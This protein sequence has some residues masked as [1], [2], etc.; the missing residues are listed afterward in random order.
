[1]QKKRRKRKLAR[2]T[3]GM[4]VVMCPVLPGPRCISLVARLQGHV[5]W[6]CSRW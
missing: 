2:G 5:T 3:V 1:M 6:F 4:G